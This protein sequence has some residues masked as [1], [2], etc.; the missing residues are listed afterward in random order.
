[1][2]WILLGIVAAASAAGVAICGRV[3][4]SGVDTMLATTLRSLVMSG[5]LAALCVASG[6]WRELTGGASEIDGRA[7]LYIVAAG[8]LGAISWLALFG[9]LK[10]GPAGPVSA[11]DRLSLPLVFLIGVAALGETPGWSGWLGVALATSG[12]LLI[13]SD[14]VRA[15]A[16]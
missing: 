15:S 11:L 12:I 7:W 4:L 2:S 9:A 14:A 3:G 5:A 13:A 10:I 6:R 1:M 16:A 8:A